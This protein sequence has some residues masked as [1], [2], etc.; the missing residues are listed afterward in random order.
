MTWRWTILGLADV[1]I[2]GS[3]LVGIGYP[4]RG[5]V[6]I[7]SFTTAGHTLLAGLWTFPGAIQQP[8][9]LLA[10]TTCVS[11]WLLSRWWFFKAA[12][13]TSDEDRD[14]QMLLCHDLAEQA[15]AAG[16]HEEAYGALR[17]AATVDP[18]DLNTQVRLARISAVTGRS[19]EARKA[20]RRVGQLDRGL[21]FQKE[22]IA[23][24]G[25]LKGRSKSHSD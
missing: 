1:I 4:F 5:I 3:G 6:M 15:L 25:H 10:A 23:A 22:R 17:V 12:R 18:A 14:E 13:A 21:A 24:L 20:W 19:R 9:L 2:P 16:R 8:V 7:A 11:T